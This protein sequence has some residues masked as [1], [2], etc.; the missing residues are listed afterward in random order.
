LRPV[1]SEIHKL[2]DIGKQATRI[3]GQASSPPQNA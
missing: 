2:R 1:T 3:S